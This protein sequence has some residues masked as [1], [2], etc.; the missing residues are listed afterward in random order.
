MGKKILC[1]YP[2]RVYLC[3]VVEWVSNSDTYSM[4]E[5]IYIYCQDRYCQ[6][7]LPVADIYNGGISLRGAA[8]P[9]H[10]IEWAAITTDP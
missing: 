2:V 7:K 3:C 4:K 1:V 8:R 6:K 10:R 9:Q 5:P